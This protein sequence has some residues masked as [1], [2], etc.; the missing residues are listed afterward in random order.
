MTVPAGKVWR[1]VTDPDLV[2]LWT[3]TGQGA[4][5]VGLAPVAGTRF[6]FVAKPVV[7]DEI[8][9]PAREYWIAEKSLAVITEA[10]SL[11]AG[12]LLFAATI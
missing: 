10:A 2:P 1:A 3:A 4:P 9:W 8:V 7:P 12:R 11:S 6:Q 5:P